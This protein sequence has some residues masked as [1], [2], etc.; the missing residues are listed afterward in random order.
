MDFKKHAI[1]LIEPYVVRGDS[2]DSLKSSYL[3]SYHDEIKACI[4]DLTKNT[5]IFIRDI[6]IT[7]DTTVIKYEL[8]SME[9][10]KKS[11]IT[12]TNDKK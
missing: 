9:G 11:E 2:Y 8:F 3:G 12:L 1:E 7:Q 5:N 10:F 4:E 6:H